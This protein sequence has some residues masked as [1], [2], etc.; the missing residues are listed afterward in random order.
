VE[1]EQVLMATQ[2][3]QEMELQDVPLF[4]AR[5]HQLVVVAAVELV[6]G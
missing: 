4:L 2:K 5:S 1:V 6:L 3:L